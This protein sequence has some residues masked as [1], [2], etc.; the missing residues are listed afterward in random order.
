M[1][2]L[3]GHMK[4]SVSY[5]I[6]W[7]HGCSMA[8]EYTEGGLVTPAGSYVEGCM[9]GVSLPCIQVAAMGQ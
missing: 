5:V 8:E 1:A 9:L 2:L 7:V 4:R 6:L 3:A